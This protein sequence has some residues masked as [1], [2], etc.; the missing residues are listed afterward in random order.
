MGR[1]AAIS[2]VRPASFGWEIARNRLKLQGRF[3]PRLGKNYCQ[4]NG[5]TADS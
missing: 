2:Y 5:R 3:C 1:Q 4:F